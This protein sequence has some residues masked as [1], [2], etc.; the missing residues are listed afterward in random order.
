MW[1]KSSKLCEELAPS[2]PMI[3]CYAPQS[4]FY[5][6]PFL[7]ETRLNMLFSPTL[8]AKVIQEVMIGND[9]SKGSNKD[10]DAIQCCC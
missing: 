3:N 4:H 8:L 5:L 9:K 6:Y 2:S 10:N 7:G 1:E